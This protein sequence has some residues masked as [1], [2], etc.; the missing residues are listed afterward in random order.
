MEVR[1]VVERGRRRTVFRLPDG[2]GV[3]GRGRG[4]TLRVPSAEVSRQHCE[5]RQDD[6]LLTVED[7][8]SVN[9]TF[10]NGARVTEP[11][12][13]RPGDRLQVGPVTFVVEYDL[14]PRALERLLAVGEDE[15]DVGDE[16]VAPAIPLDEDPEI[17]AAAQD[18]V[19]LDLSFIDRPWQAPAG[20]DLRDLLAQMED[21]GPAPPAQ[22]RPKKKPRGE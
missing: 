15:E 20:G 2:A 7:L 21:E 17:V 8:G 19:A 6:G 4:N 1:L 18:E 5:L 3:V 11:Q 16:E 14:S 22:K 13:V 10:L 9:G 12:V